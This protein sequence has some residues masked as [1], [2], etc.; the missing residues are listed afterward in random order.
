MSL[1]NKFCLRPVRGNFPFQHFVLD[2]IFRT[3]P[4][5]CRVGIPL[6]TTPFG[7]PLWINPPVICPPFYKKK[8]RNSGEWWDREHL[9]RG[10]RE[11]TFHELLLWY[12]SK[13]AKIHAR[14]TQ[15]RTLANWLP[16]SKARLIEIHHLNTQSTMQKSQCVCTMWGFLLQGVSLCETFSIPSSTSDFFR[17][18]WTLLREW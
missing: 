16:L 7:R 5:N 6:E 13:S 4:G 17:T 9:K 18:S 10:V 12:V 2:K 11:F 15:Y 1:T 3:A 14:W 8:S